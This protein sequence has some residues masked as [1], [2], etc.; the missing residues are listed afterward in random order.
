M[1]VTI[2]GTGA[3]GIAL[4]SM[5]LKNNCKI[6]MWT[7]NLEEYKSLE[8]NRC[9][10]KALPGYYISKDIK[11][12]MNMEEAIQKA[13]IIVIAIPVQYIKDLVLEVKKYYNKNGHICIASKGILG[14]NQG[15]PYKVVK[16]ILHTKNISVISGPTFAIDMVNDALMG[17]VVAGKNVKTN[18]VIKKALANDTLVVD[19]SNDIDG[20]ELCGAIKN[21]MAIGSGIID[22]MNY[23]ESTR[24][25]LFTKCF[26]EMMNLIYGLGGHK[27]SALTYAGIGDLLLTCTSYKSRNYTY[28]KLLG[29]NKN[30]EEINDY[31]SKTTIEG[32]YTLKVLY[33]M[34]KRKKIKFQIITTL[35]AIVYKNSDP[36][37]LINYLKK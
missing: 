16:K 35:Y 31:V 2:L 32:R 15:L 34:L 25:M 6:T 9:N 8:K 1:N 17:L 12:T 21:I 7:K 36:N 28:G 22:G 4:S 24:C 26:Q 33:E 20:I 29:Q 23:P 37:L 11:F 3:Y 30:K 10:E 19:T 27:A 5:F 13:E 14:D 18:M